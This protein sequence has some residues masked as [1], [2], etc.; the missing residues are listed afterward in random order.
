[1][2]SPRIISMP[3]NWSV[4]RAG[5]AIVA[6]VAHGTAGTDSRAY[7]Q[8]GGERPD[9]SDRG[10]S[11]HTLIEKDG[12]IYRMV[13][14]AR[15]ANHAGAAS[16]R[17]RVGGRTYAAGEINRVTLS[18]ELENLQDGHDPYPPAQLASMA[19]QIADWRRQYGP[20]P[21]VRHADI[22]PTRRSDPVGL[23]VAAIEE[24][25]ARL[26]P[27]PPSPSP[28]PSA[29]VTPERL[30][31]A[32]ARAP[33]AQARAYLAT[34]PSVY[35]PGD[36]DTIV[37]HYWRIAP[38]T[39]LD[40]LIALSQCIHETTRVE[41]GWFLSSWWAQ[42]PRRNPAGIGVTGAKPRITK[43]AGS[44]W[45]FDERDQRWHTGHSF[46]SWAD[47]IRAQVGRLLAF[48]L[49]AGMADAGQRSAIAYALSVRA[50]P[51][52]LRGTAPTLR[53]LGTR[54]APSVEYGV[55]IALIARAIQEYR[56]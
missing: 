13:E 41:D 2:N 15:G 52:G 56:P 25:V 47:G 44:A 29:P 12:T 51:T 7:L 20:L 53:D 11:I 8:R 3:A 38:A 9:G 30:L 28:A 32:P 17:M 50:L 31:I 39:G 46:D 40:P 43:P 42:R 19:W 5:Q 48:A 23:S 6:I 36:L 45:A 33:A 34:R 18:F 35:T 26:A 1:M 54:W 14:D 22:D 27:V 37:G 24:Q 10:V 21:I 16:A 4:S 49:P 55:Q